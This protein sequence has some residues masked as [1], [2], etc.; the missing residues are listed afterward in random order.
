MED[1]VL[2]QIQGKIYC[3]IWLQVDFLIFYAFEELKSIRY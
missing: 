3:F 2:A 1:L